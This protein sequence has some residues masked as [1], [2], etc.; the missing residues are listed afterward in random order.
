MKSH[1]TEQDRD[2][3]RTAQPLADIS[4]AC[5]LRERGV[6]RRYAALLFTVWW[7]SVAHAGPTPSPAIGKLRNGT[8]PHTGYL[9]LKLAAWFVS[10][11]P[12]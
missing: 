3:L 1:Q 5:S 11:V 6:L 4:K 10:P 7:V 9:Q 8:P 12:L 2:R